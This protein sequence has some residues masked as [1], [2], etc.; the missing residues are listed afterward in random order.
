[1]AANVKGFWP[2][3]TTAGAPWNG[4]VTRY[5]VPS[6][7]GT[8]IYCGDAV[9]LA[10]TTDGK[11]VRAVT[12]AAAG[13][14]LVGIMI[15][16]APVATN[17]FNSNTPTPDLNTPQYRAAST[18]KYVY[19]VDDPN[20]EF[21]AYVSTGI[22]E[23]DVG[24]N[25]NFTATAGSAY[26]GMSAEVIDG[27]TEATTATLPFKIMEVVQSPD[28]DPSATALRLVVKINNHQLASST[29]TAGV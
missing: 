4:Q 13:D 9:K 11:G 17:G 5:Y 16:V 23:A 19:V 21:T 2:V 1:M 28:V 22:A 15:G 7:D 25:V 14:A 27:A 8:A 3:R 24:L 20:V 12:R 6:S 26:T 10:G 18:G 29:G